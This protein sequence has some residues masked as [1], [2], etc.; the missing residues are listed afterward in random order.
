MI[1]NNI[2]IIDDDIA[3]LESTKLILEDEGY[4]VTINTGRLR[5][6]KM[7]RF[8]DL[9]LLDIWMSGV[10]GRDICKQLKTH[11]HTQHIPIIILS[12]HTNIE[13]IC[14]EVGADGFIS[15]P[16]GMEQLLTTVGGYLRKE[17]NA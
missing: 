3:I 7:K 1:K 6:K 10:D 11:P 8:P 13:Q 4:R 16:F 14:L 5:Y 9:I 17:S 12:A 15:K 2:L